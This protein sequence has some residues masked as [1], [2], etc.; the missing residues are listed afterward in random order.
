MIKK[1]TIQTVRLDSEIYMLKGFRQRICLFKYGNVFTSFNYNTHFVRHH[2]RAVH[3]TKPNRLRPPTACQ[4]AFTSPWHRSFLA[5]G[6]A[7]VLAKLHSSS[8]RH[9]LSQPSASDGS[10][11]FTLYRQYCCIRPASPLMR[12]S[13]VSSVAGDRSPTP[14]AWRNEYSANQSGCWSGRSLASVRL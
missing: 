6:M 8:A 4:N 10:P 5:S 1:K 11:C 2:P 12:V 14:Y 9:S 3:Y 7:I 13:S